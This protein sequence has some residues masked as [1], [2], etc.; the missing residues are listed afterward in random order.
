[1]LDRD[2]PRVR[3]ALTYA[4][5]T[6]ESAIFVQ[7]PGVVTAC[8]PA[9]ERLLATG[10]TPSGPSALDALVRVMHARLPRSSALLAEARLSGGRPRSESSGCPGGRPSVWLTDAWCGRSWEP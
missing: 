9:I 6:V 2:D 5:S 1:M 7:D 4:L 8:R 3:D 10:N